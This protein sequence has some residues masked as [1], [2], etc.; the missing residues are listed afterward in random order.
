MQQE[1]HNVAFCFKGRASCQV[2]SY[3]EVVV[4]FEGRA[5]RQGQ[6]LLVVEIVDGNT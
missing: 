4:C 5:F 3:D 1:K 2:Q 6:S